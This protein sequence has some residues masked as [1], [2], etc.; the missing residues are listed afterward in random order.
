MALV[1]IMSKA[2]EKQLKIWG[3]NILK[4]YRGQ[5]GVVYNGNASPTLIM[6]GQLLYAFPNTSSAILILT[7]K[8]NNQ[9]LPAILAR[10]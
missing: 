7:N 1:P 3:K 2:K 5:R 10:K 9:Q 8:R 6:R 4:S